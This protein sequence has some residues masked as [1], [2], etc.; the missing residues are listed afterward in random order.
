MGA[1]VVANAAFYYT[2]VKDVLQGHRSQPSSE[3][4][5]YHT[6]VQQKSFDLP[7]KKGAEEYSLVL[8]DHELALDDV[9]LISGETLDV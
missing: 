7:R 8:P 2:L 3:Q 9:L 6:Q 4:P 5:N 1:C